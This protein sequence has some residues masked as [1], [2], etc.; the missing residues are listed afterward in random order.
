MNLTAHI[1]PDL[2]V[3]DMRDY[4][5]FLSAHLQFLTGLCTLAMKSVNASI[6]QFLSSLL[7]TT[8]LQPPIELDTS[9]RGLVQQSKSD[10]PAT[11]ARLISSMSAINH[12]NAIISTYGTNFRYYF[13]RWYNTSDGGKYTF[14]G[15][16]N[17]KKR[18]IQNR[19]FLKGCSDERD[20]PLYFLSF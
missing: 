15:D 10:A 6:D 12:G 9:I 13:P 8:E 7:I 11:F 3:Y 17:A 16:E 5:R 2:S 14:V 20:S 1:A 19:A 18:F 4:R